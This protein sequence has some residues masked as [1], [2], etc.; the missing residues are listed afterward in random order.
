M[1]ISSLQPLNERKYLYVIFATILA[2]VLLTASIGPSFLASASD[3]DDEEVIHVDSVS[4]T[5]P[6]TRVLLDFQLVDGQTLLTPHVETT[7]SGVGFNGDS[8][9]IQT[10]WLADDGVTIPAAHAFAWCTGCVDG[11]DG[12]L[13]WRTVWSGRVDAPPDTRIG[14]WEVLGGTGDLE[15]AKGGGELSFPPVHYVGKIILAEADDDNSS[16]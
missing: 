10:V 15:G 12:T 11:K 3:D 1:N 9:F 8:A 5:T 14:T 13:F 7:L 16:D 4:P 2:A 6:V